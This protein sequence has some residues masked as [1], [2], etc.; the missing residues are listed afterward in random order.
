M[1]WLDHEQFDHTL[2]DEV[3]PVTAEKAAV[4]PPDS[5][6]KEAYCCPPAE[7]HSYV[8]RFVERLE[9]MT[10]LAEEMTVRQVASERAVLLLVGMEAA[11]GVVELELVEE[12]MVPAVAVEAT[13]DAEMETADAA[14][15]AHGVTAAEAHGVTAA[16]VEES[17][18]VTLVAAVVVVGAQFVDVV[19]VV[20]VVGRAVVV[21]AAAVEV[22]EL[23]ELAAA[24][25]EQLAEM[26]EVVAA[27]EAA[28]VIEIAGAN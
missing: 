23:A 11:Y 24:A 3:F 5:G 8:L 17:A 10:V 22:A 6:L 7:E 16:P 28:V 12:K 4:V 25:Y 19:D 18:V 20:D 14:A 27:T 9:E 21:V 2:K 1:L 15:Q 13:D 26:V